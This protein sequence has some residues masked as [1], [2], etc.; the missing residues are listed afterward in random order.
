MQTIILN[1]N[2]NTHNKSNTQTIKITENQPYT[3]SQD[4]KHQINKFQ[5]QTIKTKQTTNPNLKAT[6]LQITRN[7]KHH[8]IR[9]ITTKSPKQN[10]KSQNTP[11]L[12]HQTHQT[13]TNKQ[14]ITKLQTPNTKH[15]RQAITEKQQTPGN[16]PCVGSKTHHQPNHQI[17]SSQNQTPAN[18]T[19]QQARIKTKIQTANRKPTPNKE[20][21]R[22]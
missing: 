3:K 18:S 8:K 10:T 17:T 4:R 20:N 12:K 19:Y 2:Q 7:R 9:P 6:T 1:T 16:L 5:T 22:K 21:Y 15:P 13:H 11:T 14:K